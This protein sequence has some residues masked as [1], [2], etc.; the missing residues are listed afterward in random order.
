MLFL[1]INGIVRGNLSLTEAVWAKVVEIK[2]HTNN[3]LKL[4]SGLVYVRIERLTHSL[5]DR[6]DGL[7]PTKHLSLKLLHNFTLDCLVICELDNRLKQL[8]KSFTSTS[9]YSYF[10]LDSQAAL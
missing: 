5:Y 2:A 9:L 7:R 10:S 8:Y 3:T 1:V 6:I 4:L